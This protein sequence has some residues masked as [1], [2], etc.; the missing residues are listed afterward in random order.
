MELKLSW[1]LQLP[2]CSSFILLRVFSRE[3]LVSSGVEV[4]TPLEMPQ[5]PHTA[6]D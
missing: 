6:G 4:L 3:G 2:P 1:G 5:W